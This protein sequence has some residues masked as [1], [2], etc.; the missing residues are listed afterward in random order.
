MKEIVKRKDLLSSLLLLVA[1]GI[2][3]KKFLSFYSKA[4]FYMNPASYLFDKNLFFIDNYLEPLLPYLLGAYLLLLLNL[5]LAIS[6]RGRAR[7]QLISAGRNDKKGMFFIL[8][9][10]VLAS[11]ILMCNVLWV[12]TGTVIILAFV[13]AFVFYSIKTKDEEDLDSYEV[14]E[15]VRQAGPFLTEDE[16]IAYQQNFDSQWAEY[17]KH[18][19]FNLLSKTYQN[20]V[21]EY[22]LEFF[23]EELR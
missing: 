23:L 8:G 17:F 18:K 1:W 13:T 22:F 14:N 16:V 10:A 5:Y 9:I 19:N 12:I 7:K 6:S 21:G 2:Y 20:Q 15:V 11:V 4:A 3:F